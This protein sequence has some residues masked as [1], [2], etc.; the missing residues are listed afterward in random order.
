MPSFNADGDLNYFVART[1]D[2]DSKM[3]YLNAKVP[4]KDVIF[5]EINIDWSSELTLVEG[6][7]DLTK[8]N[9]NATCLLGSHFS[10]DYKLFQQIIK[11]STPVLMALDP[12]VKLKTQEYARKLSSYGIRIR[13][14][15][16]GQFS[17]VGEMSK[18]DFACALQ[19][20][21]EWQPDDRLY[22]LFDTVKSGSIL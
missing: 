22:N 10:E 6:P 8:C 21:K 7:F 16:L 2:D 4:K 3:K 15:D 19:K 18:L 11:N 1:I 5:N 12:D 9:D 20:A 14:L 13:M 17:D